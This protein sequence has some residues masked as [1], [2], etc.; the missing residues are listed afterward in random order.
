MMLFIDNDSNIL[1]VNKNDLLMPN[2]GYFIQDILGKA[3]SIILE[4]KNNVEVP[5]RIVKAHTISLLSVLENINK[6]DLNIIGEGNP[7]SLQWIT[8]NFDDNNAVVVEDL[9]S[10]KGYIVFNSSNQD[11]E[12]I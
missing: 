7:R 8:Y 5:P 10:N 2:T 3:R 9:E 1:Q 6:D 12:Y 11:I 4:A